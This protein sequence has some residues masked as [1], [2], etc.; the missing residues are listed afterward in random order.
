MILS[1]NSELT[2]LYWDIGNTINEHSVW[3]DKFIENLARDIKL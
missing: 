2:L 1:A 3:G